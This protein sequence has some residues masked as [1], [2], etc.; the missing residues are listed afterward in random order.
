VNTRRHGVA[1]RA[2]A[3]DLE[4]LR[5]VLRQ[6]PDPIIRADEN[7]LSP[8]DVPNRIIVRGTW[9]LPGSGYSRRSTSGGRFSAFAVDEPG[10]VGSGI[11]R[12][13]A[14]R[15]DLDF[16]LV[17]PV[18]VPNAL[19]RGGRSHTSSTAGALRDVQNNVTSPDYGT[20]Y[21]QLPLDR[22]RLRLL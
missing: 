2:H 6:L 13:A 3:I 17:R 1:V 15:D 8:T 11:G 7:S 5:S 4:R 10:F 16:S 22:V 18:E 14:E 12:P 19:Q 20:F 21:N 9:G